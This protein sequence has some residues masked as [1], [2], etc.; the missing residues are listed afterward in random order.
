[1]MS[2]P[3]NTTAH[4]L[5]VLLAG[6]CLL[7]STGCGSRGSF[8]LN[9][10]MPARVA[11]ATQLAN[12]A[13]HAEKDG[14][15]SRAIRLYSDA[16]AAYPDFHPAWNNLGVLLMAEQ[17]YAVAADAFR[18]AAELA[19]GDPRPVTNLALIY[20]NRGYDQQAAEYFTQAIAR[21]NSYLPA[22]RE[23]V[24]LDV[25]T[26]RITDITSERVAR[27]L[28][29]ETDLRW[30]EQLRRYKSQ[31]DQRLAAQDGLPG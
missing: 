1:M 5:A 17:N 12:E 19:P 9:D 27:A 18:R 23:S 24:R 28:L 11:R 3:A 16:V 7:T 26:D 6:V 21:D 30:I 22:L 2:A 15:T 8:S 20:L 10:D 29:L 4:A 13:Q 14:D 25:R 31:I